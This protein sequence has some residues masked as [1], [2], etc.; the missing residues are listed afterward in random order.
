MAKTYADLLS[1]LKWGKARLLEVAIPD[2]M[3]VKAYDWPISWLGE[4]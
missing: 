4:V 2:K 1:G 3:K